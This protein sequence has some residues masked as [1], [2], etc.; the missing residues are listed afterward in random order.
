MTSNIWGDFFGNP[1]PPRA[2]LLAAVYARYTPDVLGLQEAGPS[3]WK[4]S[5]IPALLEKYAQVPVDTGE[6]CLAAHQV[7]LRITFCRE[8]NSAYSGYIT[9]SEYYRIL[10]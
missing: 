1:V 10:G 7:I 5:L 2:P 9:Y 4:S 6:F 3:W 8:F